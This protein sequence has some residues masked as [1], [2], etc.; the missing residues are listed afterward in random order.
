VAERPA[1]TR[2]LTATTHAARTQ[3]AEGVDP[4]RTEAVHTME[5]DVEAAIEAEELEARTAA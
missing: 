3:R 1:S 2:R 5:W 4:E